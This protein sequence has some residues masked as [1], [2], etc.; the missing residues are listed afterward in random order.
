MSWFV[1]SFYGH[2]KAP[3]GEELQLEPDENYGGTDDGQEYRLD[4][5][6]WM[7]LRRMKEDF[8]ELDKSKIQ[9]DSVAQLSISGILGL[10]GAFFVLTFQIHWQTFLFTFVYLICSG[11]GVTMGV[12][13]LWSHRTYKA[14]WPA[15]IVIMLFNCLSFQ[16]SILIW[17]HKHRVHHKWS[18]TDRDFTNSRR[19]FFFAHVGW[20]MYDQ[21]PE[22][23][24]GKSITDCKDLLNDP[25][26]MFQ[27]N[28]Y[29]LISVP[30]AFIIPALIPILGWGEDPFISICI[31][32]LR[33]FISFNFT[34][35][36]NSISHMYGYRPHD[37]TSYTYDNDI[38][39]RF[40]LGEGLHN[41]HHAYPHDYRS[42]EHNHFI[43]SLTTTMIDLMAFFGLVW[44]RREV[45]AEHILARRKRT[46]DLGNMEPRY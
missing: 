24:F 45:T 25:I 1:Q 8:V 23:A 20:K 7:V 11:L 35:C 43:G 9:W 26:V 3:T 37:V 15:Q 38:Y 41:F 46:G 6:F 19:G 17:S 5:N 27:H 13:R 33:L 32:F 39:S 28:Y 31:V 44:D 36:V 42:S 29:Y 40:L 30:V 2:N 16:E 22:V 14:V 12:H 34:W 18:D 21:H 4:E 10:I